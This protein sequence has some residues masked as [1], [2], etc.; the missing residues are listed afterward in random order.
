M[1]DFNIAEVSVTHTYYYSTSEYLEHCNLNNL[2]PTEADFLEYIQSDIDNDFPNSDSHIC[3][4]IY[5]TCPNI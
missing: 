4:V 1:P 2:E 5:N 3:E